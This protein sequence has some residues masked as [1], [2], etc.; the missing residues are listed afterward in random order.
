MT[1]T[2]CQFVDEDDH[3]FVPF[4]SMYNRL[5][6]RFPH[7]GEM[8]P[9]PFLILLLISLPFQVIS[10]NHPTAGEW[11][12]LL[13]LK[14]QLGNPP[15]LQSW[16]SKSSPCNWPEIFCTGN[17][18]TEIFLRNK[19]ITQKIPATICDLKNLTTLDL[20]GN[21][22]PG[23]FPRELYNCTKLQVLDLSSNY[24]VGLI[25]DC[26]DRILGL[27][28]IDLGSN[29]FSGDIPPAIGRLSELQVLHLYQNEF[30]GTFPVEIGDLSNLRVLSLAYNDKFVPAKIPVE[31]GKLKNL[32]SLRFTGVNL[33]G[34]IPDCLNNL[35]SLET[36]D[37]SRNH[38]EGKIP[39]WV[40]KFK[41]LTE[42]YLNGNRLSGEIPKTVE[43]L[44]LVEID[45]SMN[46][47]TGS[48][49]ED[50]GK[51]QNLQ[52]LSLHSNQLSGEIPSSI[53]LIPN[54]KDFWV[55]DNNLSGV[56][57][58][59]LGLHS[60]LEMV[61]V[62]HNRAIPSSFCN[63]SS[64]QLLDLSYNNLYGEIPQCL[65]NSTTI[66]GLDLRMNNFHGS[67]PQTFSN[68][69][70]LKTMNLNGN[71]LEGSLPPSL[72]NCGNLEVL[73]VGNNK[74]NDTFPHWLASIPQLQ[75]LILRSNKFH[76]PLGNS[77]TR[78]PFS[79]LR[80]LDL[81]HNGFTGPLRT[82]F[83]RRFKA[84]MS[85]KN[86][87][88]ERRYIGED[89]AEVGHPVK[90]KCLKEYKGGGD[91]S[92]YDMEMESNRSVESSKEE[93]PFKDNKELSVK[94]ERWE[95]CSSED[96]F[97]LLHFK[98]TILIN[99]SASSHCNN[100]A[101][102]Y[103][104]THSWKQGSDCC[105]W[106]GVTCDRFTGHVTALYLSSSR[107]L[108]TVEVNSSLFLLRNL[109]K[110]NLACNDFKDPE[111]HQI[112]VI[113]HNYLQGE[114]PN[115]VL[116]LPFLQQL[117]LAEN[118]GLTGTFPVSNWSSPLRLFNLSFTSFSGK[119][120]HT[121]GN[122]P[123]LN[124]LDLA[125]CNFEGP[126]PASF[127]S[128]TQIT[129]L[130]LSSNHFTGQISASLSKLVRLTDLYLRHNMFSGQFL[131]VFRNLRKVKEEESEQGSGEEAFH[132]CDLVIQGPKPGAPTDLSRMR[133]ILLKLKHNAPN[134][135][136]PAPVAPAL[137]KDT[138][139]CDVAAPS[140]AAVDAN[141]TEVVVAAW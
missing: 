105:S 125:F 59:E 9:L 65:G 81:S 43:T 58:S 70:H 101:V 113:T 123:N 115:E 39:S 62:S 7:K 77:R 120:P 69:C 27:R 117:I 135:L 29:S 32:T 132:C 49:P 34:E 126:V 51:L 79:M 110:L 61:A 106:D 30:N 136:N 71:Q 60:K 17:S 3:E 92:F 54:L 114:F 16:N 21:F 103:P 140:K 127:W 33:I 19:A 10:Q 121:I 15:S 104:K 111:C 46:N 31:F 130:V 5:I 68:G 75:V 67:I 28:F 100:Y 48:V 24:F 78:H 83:F 12:V 124:V 50:F 96:S 1:K 63:L 139:T 91:G 134:H 40:F 6:L 86:I 25:P 118:I 119:L 107:L 102:S 55:F 89:V 11:T 112:F 53:G 141:P 44:N 37:L 23:E 57:P 137:S 36:L 18:V 80:I 66:W 47:L 2:L 20:A 108:G 87:S 131:D 35:S 116:H 45:L 99:T 42:L 82:R 88:A 13:K 94:S 52:L 56:L 129:S 90:D 4:W 128:L 74:I 133:Q 98:N 64:L 93:M 85:G 95:L 38:L 97:A 22:I 72:V 109:K 138:K 41:N 26:I 14:Q 122:L 8:S 84:M 76:G 73:D